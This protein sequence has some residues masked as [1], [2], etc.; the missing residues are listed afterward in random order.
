MK[1]ANLFVGDTWPKRRRWLKII[2]GWMMV[3]AQY[4]IIWGQ[5]NALHQ[6]ALITL[7]GAIVASLGSYVFG[8]VFDD[9]DK[10][11]R[12]LQSEQGE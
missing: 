11:K 8:A 4:L 7:L 6:N 2:I 3:N 9:N 12:Q 10:R 5:D 1:P